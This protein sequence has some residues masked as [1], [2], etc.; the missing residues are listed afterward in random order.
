MN[1]SASRWD[2]S[3]GLAFEIWDGVRRYKGIRQEFV[4]PTNTWGSAKVGGY[5][6]TNTGHPVLSVQKLIFIHFTQDMKGMTGVLARNEADVAGTILAHC[7]NRETVMD[8]TMPI[9]DRTFWIYFTQP[10]MPIDIF[11]V[12]GRGPYCTFAGDRKL[13]QK[14]G[15]LALMFNK[16]YRLHE[17]PA[18]ACMFFVPSLRSSP[19]QCGWPCS[20]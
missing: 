10:E 5:S 8:Y 11:T 6:R 14:G 1:V 2:L 12:Q 13:I 18:N 15:N 9:A 3:H 4:E 17:P 19:G 7:C 20:A 16:D